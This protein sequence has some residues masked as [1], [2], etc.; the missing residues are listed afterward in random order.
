MVSLD[1]I[2]LEPYR[3]QNPKEMIETVCEKMTLLVATGDSY[4]NAENVKHLHTGAGL[5]AAMTYYNFLNYFGE[6]HGAAIYNGV[7]I[8]NL[9]IAF[10]NCDYF[11]K[12]A[13]YDATPADLEKAR[14]GLLLF[15]NSLHHQEKSF[16]ASVAEIF[17]FTRTLEA[18]EAGHPKLIAFLDQSK[19]P[20]YKENFPRVQTLDGIQ[21]GNPTFDE[22]MLR[23]DSPWHT[24]E[25]GRAISTVNAFKLDNQNF[26]AWILKKD[27]PWLSAST[28]YETT[29]MGSVFPHNS[30]VYE[31]ETSVTVKA[32]ELGDL[33]FT[34]WILRDGSPWLSMSLRQKAATVELVNLGNTRINAWL[35]EN[36]N[37]WLEKNEHDMQRTISAL[38]VGIP[39]VVDIVIGQPDFL[40]G[41]DYDLFDDTQ[42]ALSKIK[43]SLAENID[44]QNH[45]VK[46]MLRENSP[47]FRTIVGNRGPVF[48]LIEKKRGDLFELCF[49]YGRGKEKA[50]MGPSGSF[51]EQTAKIAKIENSLVNSYLADNN[52]IWRGAIYLLCNVRKS[53]KHSPVFLH[54]QMMQKLPALY[55]QGWFI[56]CLTLKGNGLTIF[57]NV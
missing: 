20:W 55:A 52:G 30:Y 24:I 56:F 45:F 44:Q 40:C 23:E 39:A 34:N 38:R 19:S 49:G 2:A 42:K 15:L 3:Y 53:K 14:Q 16:S 35:M 10:Q 32:V 31:T 57:L 7:M 18:Y 27:S 6:N 11:K 41:T 51:V 46:L 25:A 43:E 54:Q 5:Q 9:Y 50:K 29:Y 1:G 22:W 28:T 13:L 17:D 21:I 47:W 8:A 33:D 4:F 37:P 36:K 12:I 26:N 48:D